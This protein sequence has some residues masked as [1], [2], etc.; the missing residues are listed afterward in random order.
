MRVPITETENDNDF[1][2]GDQVSTYLPKEIEIN[3]SKVSEWSDEEFCFENKSFVSIL[4]P[5]TKKL[6]SSE[7]LKSATKVLPKKGES[8]KTRSLDCQDHSTPWPNPLSKLKSCS[9]IQNDP[10][11]TEWNRST[12]LECS[13][14]ARTSWMRSACKTQSR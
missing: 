8:T 2:C 6:L 13:V 9:D 5:E 11:M 12:T 1:D 7:D 14:Q 4:S 3:K 10:S